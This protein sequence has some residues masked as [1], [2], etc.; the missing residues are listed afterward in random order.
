MIAEATPMLQSD[1]A[2]MNNVQNTNLGHLRRFLYED[3]D[4]AIYNEIKNKSFMHKLSYKILRDK[5]SG[6]SFYDMITG[7]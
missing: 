5:S 1:W 4:E 3:F 2:R 6:K 7:V